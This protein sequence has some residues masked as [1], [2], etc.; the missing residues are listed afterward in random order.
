MKIKQQFIGTIINITETPYKDNDGKNRISY[1]VIT[2]T[3]EDAGP[4]PCLE[5]IV[6]LLKTYIG[7]EVILVT[8]NDSTSKCYTP[9]KII[10]AKTIP[11][12]QNP[13]ANTA[14]K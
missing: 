13:A 7:Q 3:K 4:L 8:M 11:V 5:D 6:P 2:A 9:V 14:K 12:N 10:D 1:K